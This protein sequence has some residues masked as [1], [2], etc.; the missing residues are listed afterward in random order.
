MLSDVEVY[1]RGNT[2][3]MKFFEG[4]HLKTEQLISHE[5]EPGRHLQRW[6]RATLTDMGY[7]ALSWPWDDRAK[8]Y[9]PVVTEL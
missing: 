7:R 9:L 5:L 2:A 8:R 6:A 4:T 1:K 3:Y